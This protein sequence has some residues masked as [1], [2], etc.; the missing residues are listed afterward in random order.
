M[1]PP[2][3]R[4]GGGPQRLADL[5]EHVEGVPVAG[6]HQGPVAGRILLGE[7]GAPPGAEDGLAAVDGER[8]GRHGHV[9]G[10]GVHEGRV[11]VVPLGRG[12]A[13]GDV[14]PLHHD[15]A[16]EDGRFTR[17]TH[18][19]PGPVGRGPGDGHRPPAVGGHGPAGEGV[20]RARREVLL[21]HVVVG[22]QPGGVGGDRLDG[23][24]GVRWR[25]EH[26]R[27]P[28]AGRNG[29]RGGAGGRAPAGGQRPADEQ[30]EGAPPEWSVRVAVLHDAFP[31]SPEGARSSHD[32][33][34]TPGNSSARGR[35]GDRPAA[36]PAAASACSRS[37][38]LATLSSVARGN[39]STT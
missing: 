10:P 26:G 28:H 8:L 20:G 23:G 4:G 35:P 29:C 1:Q 39:S 3:G 13:G 31:T 22:G 16:V 33:A 24:P 27:G 14:H 21:F 6:M 17:A 32:V 9:G 30:E 19:D 18:D 36:Q 37:L 15:V 2:E 25:A 34:R 7:A 5:G 11:E 38:F 12:L